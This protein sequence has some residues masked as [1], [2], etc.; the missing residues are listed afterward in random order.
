M[1]RF[2]ELFHVMSA[3]EDYFEAELFEQPVVCFLAG[4]IADR[5]WDVVGPVL[6]RYIPWG[7][8][9]HF[10]DE[11]AMWLGWQVNYEIWSSYDAR[12]W[13]KKVIERVRVEDRDREN[14]WRSA[15]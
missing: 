2:W 13:R 7:R 10:G 3:D 6:E 15:R 11:K 12:Q 5:T 14:W 1:A 8:G 4:L 9:V